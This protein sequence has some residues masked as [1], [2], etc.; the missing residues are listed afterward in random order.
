ME[1]GR[2]GGRKGWQERRERRGWGDGRRERGGRRNVIG[3]NLLCQ[4]TNSSVGHGLHLCL[5][6]RGRYAICTLH[7]HYIMT[8]PT[9]S[10]RS[11]M[12]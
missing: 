9:S 7:H 11:T 2:E 3:Q 8:T 1:G 12:L 10:G 6:K 4:K 5:L